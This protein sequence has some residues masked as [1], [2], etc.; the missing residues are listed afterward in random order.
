VNEIQS[1]ASWYA[2]QCDGEWEHRYGIT[3]ETL[4]NPGWRLKVD[5]C[6]TVLAGLNVERTMTESSDTDWTTWWVEDDVFQAAG[7]AMSLNDILAAFREFR[8]TDR[9]A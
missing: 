7:G 2:E 9:P 8:E 1:L 4:D 5:L 6:G 3:L